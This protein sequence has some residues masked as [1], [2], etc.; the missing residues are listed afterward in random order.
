MKKK[1]SLTALT[2]AVLSSALTSIQR[3]NK[4]VQTNDVSQLDRNSFDLKASVKKPMPVLK[5]NMNNIEDSKFVASHIS[6]SSHRSHGSHG[7]H[8]SHRSF[9]G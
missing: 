4:L 5:L 6:H 2:L 9:I 7:S 8:R 1:P 3:D